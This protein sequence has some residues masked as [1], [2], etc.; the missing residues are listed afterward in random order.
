M[1]GSLTPGFNLMKPAERSM[2]SG[3]LPKQ[4]GM[5][6]SGTNYRKTTYLMGK[7]MVSCRFSLANNPLCIETNGDFYWKK[8]WKCHGDGSSTS[9]G[10]ENRRPVKALGESKMPC[11]RIVGHQKNTSN[12]LFWLRGFNCN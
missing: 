10:P 11:K 6:I 12:L 8:T 1:P 5:L 2:K 7:S 4:N 3:V 9:Q